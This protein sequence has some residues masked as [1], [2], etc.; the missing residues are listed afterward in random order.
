M[1]TLVLQETEYM[2]M[3]QT[4]HLLQYELNSLKNI[5]LQYISTENV[6]LRMV[7]KQFLAQTDEININTTTSQ[8]LPEITEGDKTISPTML[9]GK[10]NNLKIDARKI[11][12]E[13]WKEY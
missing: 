10:W 9:F 7:I 3:K 8:Y 2:Q 6:D 11:R 4:V 5:F 1:K 13:S 12:R